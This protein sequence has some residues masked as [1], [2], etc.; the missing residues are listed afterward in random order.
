MAATEAAPWFLTSN[1]PVLFPTH[2]ALT[3]PDDE[4]E[5]FIVQDVGS[6]H[7][8]PANVAAECRADVATS[9]GTLIGTPPSTTADVREVL[10]AATLAAPEPDATAAQSSNPFMNALLSHSEASKAG[11]QSPDNKMLTENSDV[12]HRSSKNALVD[13]FFE[14]EDTI[15]SPRL[16]E[17]LTAAWAEDPETTLK[18]IFNARSIHLGKSSRTLF[19]RCAGWLAQ[20]HPLTLAVNLRWLS[21]PVIPK[22]AE[23]EEVDAEKPVLV[24]AA[25]ANE[26]DP[27]HHDVRHGVAHGYWKDLLNILALAANGTLNPLTDPKE[28]LNL[29]QRG[30]PEVSKMSQEDAKVKRHAAREDRHK[31]TLLKFENDAVYRALH[32]TVSRLFATQLKEDLRKLRSGDAKEMRQISLCAKWA[33]SMARFHDKHTFVVS[34]LAEL[35][36]PPAA[37]EQAEEDRETFLRH[38]RDSYRRDVAALRKQLE[39]VERDVT[40]QTFDKIKYDRVPSIA[41]QNYTPLFAAKDTERFDAYVTKVAQGKAR[42]SGAVLLPSTL[43]SKARSLGFHSANR[44]QK[45]GRNGNG[46]RTGASAAVEA[47]IVEMEAKVLDGQWAALVQRIR[48]SG[49]LPPSLAVC[50]VSGSMEDPR[51]A[52]GTTPMDSAI[53]LSLLV[54][55][56]AA[57]PFA[58]AFITFSDHPKVERVNL[59]DTFRD[60]IDSLE[61]SD[62]GMSTN[63]VAVFEKLILPLAVDN[64]IRPE[65]MVKRVFVFSDMQFNEAESGQDGWS[66]S[67]ERISKLYEAAGYEMPELVFWNL[68]GGR[69]GVTGVGDPTAP[70]P[71]T[72]DTEGTALVSGYSQGMLK[73]F[74]D[75]GGFEDPELEEEAE[76]EEELVVVTKDGEDV[77]ALEQPNKK[78]KRDSLD[79]VKRAVNHMA[80]SMLKV[81]D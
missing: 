35:L 59:A 10:A 55:E 60:K 17:V 50:D 51:R 33:P 18:I 23:K 46:G 1:F 70:K 25:E 62:W 11:P 81:V 28:L 5:S 36:S 26:H 4:F 38:A 43:V 3:L 24:N 63:F 65:D 57:P 72:A 80:Y 34:T 13:L 79:V 61:G 53:G 9:D 29:D 69:A 68:A 40:A 45:G 41:M 22:K 15:S 48:D 12:A 49:T 37:G 47:K 56:V 71:V 2:R 6:R 67:F 21:R 16:I 66:T 58:G 32:M 31:K 14:L 52:D 76:D 77:E 73:V 19:Y 27:A 78:R 42:I 75:G 39:V 20:N 64:K 44:G 54:A 74:L 8:G 30:N 7:A